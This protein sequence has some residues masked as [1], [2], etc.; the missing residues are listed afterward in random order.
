VTNLNG[1][2]FKIN[3]VLV[4]LNS[5]PLCVVE[6]TSGGR[7]LPKYVIDLRILT[8]KNKQIITDTSRRI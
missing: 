3:K 1:L 4:H 7:E 5:L 2:F 8:D 6:T